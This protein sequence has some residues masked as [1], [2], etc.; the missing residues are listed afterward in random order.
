ML[1][2]QGCCNLRELPTSIGGLTKLRYLYISKSGVVELPKDFGELRS[3]AYFDAS[4]C[5][6]LSRLP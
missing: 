5:S 1:N 6:S 4:G 2:L 3:L